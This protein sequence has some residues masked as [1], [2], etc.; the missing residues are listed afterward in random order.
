MWMMLQQ[1]APDDF[2]LATGTTTTVR[3]F[4]QKAFAAAGIS[5]SWEGE[6]DNEKGISDESGTVVV[7][8]DPRY[9]RPDGSGPACG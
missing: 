6:G 2:V 7:E 5:I 3:D 4:C 9:F 8:V 1:D